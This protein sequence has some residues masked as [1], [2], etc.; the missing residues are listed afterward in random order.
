MYKNDPREMPSKFK[1]TCDTCKGEIKKGESI[2]FW[3]SNRT[4]THYKCGETSF[5]QFKLSVQDED[6]YNSQY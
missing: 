5:S 4:A 2:I 6:F 3:P 1:S